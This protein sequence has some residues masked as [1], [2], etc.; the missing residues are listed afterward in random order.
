MT[1]NYRACYVRFERVA[2]GG[3]PDFCLISEAVCCHARPRAR[4]KDQEPL[5]L[6]AGAMGGQVPVPLQNTAS[7]TDLR[8]LGAAHAARWYSLIMPP[9]TFRRCTGASSGMTTSSS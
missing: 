2:S 8:V 1:M 3:V 6:H 9:G 4:V 7:D 5:R